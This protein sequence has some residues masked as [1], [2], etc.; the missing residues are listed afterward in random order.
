MNGKLK[1]RIF[2]M[3]KQK[4]KYAEFKKN[5]LHVV[6]YSVGQNKKITLNNLKKKIYTDPKYKSAIPYVTSYYNRDWGI[7]M[8]EN[9]KNNLPR[10]NYKVKIDSFHKKGFLEMT[11]AIIKGKS[12]KEIMFSSYICHPSMA[13]NELS[14][15]VLV[16]ELLNYINKFF[17]NN[18]YTY[19]FLLAPETIGS[20]AYL[21][22]YKSQLKKN[23]ISG[24]NLT[25]VGDE[26]SYSHISSPNNNN[27]SDKAIKSAIYKFSNSKFYSFLERGSDEKQYCFP[28]IDLPFSTFCKSKFGTFKEYH[29][30]K[31]DLNLVT[32]KGMNQS[33]NVLKNIILSFESG[34]IPENKNFCEPFLSK[35]NLY[36]T[37]S[38][39]N[40]EKNK[41]SK[42]K[43]QT[44]RDLMAYSDGKNN[45]FEIALKINKSL[46]EVLEA[47]KILKQK[48]IIIGKFI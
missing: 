12:S 36:P 25:C 23:V 44:L 32:E 18:Y 33:F 7:C 34:V 47:Y 17:K 16:L 2:S 15:P 5:N 39:Y 46:A 40:P 6:S 11:H 30:N 48:K 27:L 31:D 42:K 41:S 37:I 4:K 29:T 21:S 19:R 24:F 8:S 43:L 20:I 9:Q 28:K 35:Y 13:N 10:G 26:K 45:I 1:T 38:F 22:K 3:K 14:G